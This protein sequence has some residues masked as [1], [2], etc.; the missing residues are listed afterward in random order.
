MGRIDRAFFCRKTSL[1]AEK[2][3]EYAAINMREQPNA[4]QTR[5]QLKPQISY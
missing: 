3:E 5:E 1:N 2:K 4:A